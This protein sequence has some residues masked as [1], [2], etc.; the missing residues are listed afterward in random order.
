MHGPWADNP[1]GWFSAGY[2]P[3]RRLYGA[4]TEAQRVMS[5]PSRVARFATIFREDATLGECEL[6]L[7]ELHHRKLESHAREERILDNILR[8]LD[9]DFLENG[10]SIDRV[11]SD[12]LWLQQPNGLRI[13][14]AEMSDGYRAAL[15]MVVDILRHLVEVYGDNELIATD[16]PPQVLHQGV[17]LIDEIDA[18]LHPE[19]QRKIGFWFK[20]IFPN[21]Q[22]IVTTHSPMICQAADEGSIYRLPSP[23]SDEEPCQIRGE[24]YKRIIASPPDQILISPAFQLEEIRSPRAVDARRRYAQLKAKGAAM[25]LSPQEKKN[26]QQFELFACVSD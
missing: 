2:G 18:H 8:L 4:S 10:L 25:A 21:I 11:D 24:E 1:E 17:V 7:K 12:G 22:F 6:W 16:G 23:G 19:W 9:A 3:F 20:N 26:M 15:A 14:L 13:P 5:G